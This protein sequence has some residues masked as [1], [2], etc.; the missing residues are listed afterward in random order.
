MDYDSYSKS[1][2][3]GDSRFKR[4]KSF[5]F[6][7]DDSKAQFLYLEEQ[8]ADH[9]IIE[10]A[11]KYWVLSEFWPNKDMSDYALCTVPKDRNFAS[12]RKYLMEKDFTSTGFTA[13][14]RV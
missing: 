8:L 4:L 11:E 3:C 6:D 2:Y 12:L 14:E 1:T 5:K 7:I 13:K 10:N 9:G